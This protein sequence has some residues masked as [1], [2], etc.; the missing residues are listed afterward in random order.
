MRVA[1]SKTAI[2]ENVFNMSRFLI[3]FPNRLIIPPA[4]PLATLRRRQ[5]NRAKIVTKEKQLI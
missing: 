3:G 2:A 4:R 5:G 1:V